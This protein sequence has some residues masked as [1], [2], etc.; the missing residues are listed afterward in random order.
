MS[1]LS[2]KQLVILIVT[3]AVVAAGVFLVV[4][5]D[6]PI[7]DETQEP[8]EQETTDPEPEVERVIGQSVEGRDI[9]AHTYGQGDNHLLFVGGIHGGYEWNSVL[10]AYEFIDYFEENENQIPSDIKITII[11]SANPD[12]VYEIIGKE[13]RFIIE[14]VPDGSHASGRFNANDVD[15]NRNFDCNWKPQSTWRGQTVDAGDEPFSEPEARTIRDFV[16]END[17]DAGIFWHS[18]ANAVYG[19]ACNE[20]V[21]PETIDIMNTYAQ[22]GDYRAVELF[23]AY[24]IT[25][26]VEGWLASLGI[27][28][29]SVELETHETVEWE[30]NLSGV[31]ALFDY[32]TSN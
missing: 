21:L 10:L 8:V 15:L 2:T 1:Y 14:D 5:Q 30:R 32:Y 16:L 9:T 17:I 22:A 13:G 24:E 11:P 3:L 23:D 19:S 12:G 6:E 25:G 27:P 29:V 20:G 28:A 26:D 7:S 18:Q 31:Q 4:D